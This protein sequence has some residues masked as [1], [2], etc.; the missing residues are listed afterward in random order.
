MTEETKKKCRVCGT[1]K[2]LADYQP[3]RITRRD[4]CCRACN[5]RMKIESRKQEV[6]HGPA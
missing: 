5:S 1:L 3:S 2:P 6:S 4:W